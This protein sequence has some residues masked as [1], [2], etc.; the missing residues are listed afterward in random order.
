MSITTTL[1]LPCKQDGGHL[2]DALISDAA[3][4]GHFV[5]EAYM[6][7]SDSV[8]GLIQASAPAGHA[9]EDLVLAEVGT[10]SAVRSNRFAN[11]ASTLA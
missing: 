8:V 11:R 10:L 7:S 1:R 9:G 5:L 2:P 4:N 6:T 3:D